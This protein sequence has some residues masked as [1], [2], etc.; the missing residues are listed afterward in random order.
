M[1]ISRRPENGLRL[2]L[3]YAQCD[4]TMQIMR[5]K[6]KKKEAQQEAKSTMKIQRIEVFPLKVKKD[7]VYLGNTSTLSGRY[8]YYLRPE[9]RCPYSK[10]METLLVKITTESGLSGWG[11]ALAPVIPEAGATIVSRLFAPVLLGCDA[12]DRGVL[13]NRL[14]NLMRDRGYY[15]GFMVDAIAAV[16]CALWDLCGKAANLPVYQLLGGAYRKE[17]PAYVSGLPVEGLEE[18][19]ELALSWKEKGFNAIKLQI[20]YGM[21]EDLRIMTALRKALGDDFRL[22]IDAHWNYTAAQSVRLAHGLEELGVEFLECPMNPELYGGYAELAASVDMPIA[23]GEADRTHWQYK[24]IL[25]RGSCDILQ[26]DVGRCGITELM[27]IGELAELYGKPVAPHLS[28]GQ[29][30]CIAA[31]LQCDAALYNFYGIQEFQPSILPVAN[32]FLKNPIRCEHGSF[33]VP[34]GA[35][36]GIEIEEEKVRHYAPGWEVSE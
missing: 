7:H 14:Y 15:T 3:Q 30:A 9:Y 21:Q 31:T 5:D 1:N 2:F 25:D 23:M 19:V 10:N 29:G 33:R 35:G 22:M 4:L 32:E 24:E 28:V 11:E 20:G 16:D 8:D 36:L 13:W 34:E 18:K 12:R 26:P 17:I 27:R 6:V